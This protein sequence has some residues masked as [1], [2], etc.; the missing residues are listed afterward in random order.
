MNR[1]AKDPREAAL[2][3]RVVKAAMKGDDERDPI[4]Y[5]DLDDVVTN[6][7]EYT[8]LEVACARLELYRRKQKGK[9]D[10]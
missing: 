5:Y 10:A 8:P 4:T 9:R 1:K 7:K 6:P 3:Q 2:E